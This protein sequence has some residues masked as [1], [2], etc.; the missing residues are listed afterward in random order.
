VI[1]S[2]FVYGLPKH[3][4]TCPIYLKG[5]ITPDGKEATGKNPLGKAHHD[6]LSG[7]MS[8][9]HLLD[10]PEKFGAI[11]V[12]SGP[13]SGGVLILDVDLNLG[14]LQKKYSGCFDG[15]RVIS[16]KKNA[17]KYFFQLPE[18]EW[19]HVCDV[20]LAA[21]GEG[22]EALWGRQAVVCGPYP[23]GG[24]YTPEGDFSDLP[25]APEWLVARM[26]MHKQA[27]AERNAQKTAN[28]L[29]RHRLR[30]REVRH[31]I[32]QQCL[33]QIN[34]QGH[35]SNDFWWRIGAAIHS[36]DLGEDGLELWREWSK[37]DSEYAHIWEQGKDPCADRWSAGFNGDG[38]TIASLIKFADQNDPNR[39]RFDA[40]LKA[41]VAEDEAGGVGGIVPFS[42]LYD[43]ADEI[44]QDLTTSTSERRYRLMQLASRCGI[45]MKPVQEI[46]EMYLGEREKRMGG[47]VQ[48]SAV[49]R[50]RN[51]T[52]ASYFVPGILCSGVWLVSGRGN[53]GKTNA[54]WRFAKH[55]LSGI[56]M[57]TTDGLRTWEKGSVLWLTG[58]QPD[59]VT[60]DQ[61]RQHLTEEECENLTIYNNFNIN[62]YPTFL[63][64]AQKHKPK[65]VVV[66]SLRSTHRG[67]GISEN[68]SEFALPLRWYE[69]M[70]GQPGMFDPCM[71]YVI[72]HSGHARG[73]ARGTSA[74]G[75]MTSFTA[76]FDEPGKDSGYSPLTSRVLTFRKHRFGLKDHQMLVKLQDDQTI[77]LQYLGVPQEKTA[78]S[79]QDRVRLKLHRAP[80]KEFTI[81]ELSL[82]SQVSG[83]KEAV[84][85]AVQ[86]LIRHGL[87]RKCRGGKG[88]TSTYAADGVVPGKFG[89][90]D[91]LLSVSAVPSSETSQSTTAVSP[92]TNPCLISPL[93]QVQDFDAFWDEN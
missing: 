61:L 48:R 24:T 83:S 70:M 88:K 59:A 69:Q 91:P 30:P 15:P 84:R 21:S 72:H 90:K 28:S 20:S 53:S 13:R 37:R 71:I 5:V 79:V 86:R 46:T 73:G 62:D 34:P 22:W 17:G 4:A 60:D 85:K 92:G 44:F 19:P 27:K 87:A 74:L 40:A 11:G 56:P 7:A 36:A 16:P 23:A 45:R 50:W 77:R 1:L 6:R 82:S 2:D 58:D 3:W 68:D 29:D 25:E 49:D 76:D 8:L 89:Q 33:T 67:T 65:F 47:E 93:S 52:E 9:H 66:D 31:Q 64:L 32:V 80:T 35:G 10:E 41:A 14:Q 81:E 54:A 42:E 78:S 18:S 12:F 39:E 51:P 26:R 57:P 43:L 55:F 38:V 63:L 75:D